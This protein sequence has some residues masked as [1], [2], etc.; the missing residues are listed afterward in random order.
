MEDRLELQPTGFHSHRQIQQFRPTGVHCWRQRLHLQHPLPFL[1]PPLVVVLLH[2][3]WRSEEPQVGQP[4][5]LRLLLQLRVLGHLWSQVDER[6]VLHDAEVAVHAGPVAWDES[7]R[8]WPLPIGTC[9]TQTCA[10]NRNLGAE[11]HKP[12]TEE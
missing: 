11:I 5:G 4:P 8:R 7:P 9:L 1:T 10:S 6:L 2:E 12:R 3:S